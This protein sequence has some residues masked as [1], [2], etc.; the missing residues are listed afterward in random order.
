MQPWSSIRFSSSPWKLSFSICPGKEGKTFPSNSQEHHF[1]LW[2]EITTLQTNIMV[3][4][5]LTK[6]GNLKLAVV[7][8]N[9]N[10]PTFAG[11]K[12]TWISA[13]PFSNPVFTCIALVLNELHCLLHFKGWESEHLISSYQVKEIK[14]EECNML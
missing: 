9:L 8:S 12:S 3:T 6:I 13:T 2:N 7:I 14:Y 5:G 4:C 1:N 11:F 10:Y